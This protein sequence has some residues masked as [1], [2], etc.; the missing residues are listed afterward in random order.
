MISVGYQES[1]FYLK[2]HLVPFGEYVPFQ[3]WLGRIFNFLHIPM[4]DFSA[5]PAIMEPIKLLQG[6]KLS[7]AICYEIAF[8]ELM[9][10]SIK[11]IGLILTVTNDAWFGHSIA[12]AQHLQMA[13]MRAIELGKPVLFASNNGITALIS[14]S[15]KIESAAPPFKTSVL[16]GK[17]RPYQGNT[18]W[19]RYPM[20]P[21]LLIIIGLLFTAY[22]HRR[23]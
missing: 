15:G 3:Q 23:A 12:Q 17:V 14:A 2:R 4:S 22:R 7:T 8:P 21:I 19:A 18:P 20:D 6:I 11:K 1:G 10:A 13:Q 9:L 5:G 16:T